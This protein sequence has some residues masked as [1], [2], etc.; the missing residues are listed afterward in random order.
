MKKIFLL[1]LILC[2][3]SYSQ[4]AW[5]VVAVSPNY[6]NVYPRYSTLQQ[7]YNA[8]DDSAN[9]TANKYFIINIATATENITDWSS[10]WKDSIVNRN[11]YMRLTQF[12]QSVGDSII[13]VTTEEFNLIAGILSLDP[14]TAG[15][16]ISF[17]GHKYNIN[18]TNYLGSVLYLDSDSLK[19]RTNS[20][21][22]FTPNLLGVKRLVYSG[23]QVL[24]SGM[25]ILPRPPLKLKGDTVYI[26]KSSY[27]G[28]DSDSLWIDWN[29]SYFDISY[30]SSPAISLKLDS[31]ITL[32][33]EGLK[34]NIDNSTIKL[35]SSKKLYAD[36]SGL[37]GGDL[38][39]TS[40]GKFNVY[41][42]MPLLMDNDSTVGLNYNPIHFA[43]QPTSN[44]FSIVVDSGLTTSSSFPYDTAPKLLKDNN[45]FVFNS[46][47]ELEIAP[48]L[49]GDGLIKSGNQIN[50]VVNEFA[51]IENDTVKTK[52]SYIIPIYGDSLTSNVTSVG[53]GV[54][55]YDTTGTPILYTG[56]IKRVTFSYQLSSGNDTVKVQNENTTV[57]FG[58]KIRG[59]WNNGG[60][61]FNIQKWSQGTRTW[62][63]AIQLDFTDFA[64]KP[65]RI[66]IELYA[67][68]Q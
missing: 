38:V 46:S 17:S 20:S 40:Q 3:V 10:A 31:G 63:T 49:A 16:G 48:A 64:N 28:G 41:F 52:T 57:T 68:A 9:V 66:M 5:R 44:Y 22:Y 67:E 50:V 60:S 43:L 39:L 11:P 58:D 14:S 54:L 32:G 18:T 15:D 8:I 30:S 1:L 6:P 56:K 53:V 25:G 59:T 7:V 34:V 2:G 33:A 42:A 12:G 62:S 45:E 36:Y 27:F 23:L 19:L 37:F 21:L 55:P 47:K 61:K 51:K 35:N 4:V 24:D 65:Y 26:N 13:G 29:T